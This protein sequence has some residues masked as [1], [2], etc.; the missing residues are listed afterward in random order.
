MRKI[1]ISKEFI[2]SYDAAKIEK[3]QSNM[4]K[5][6]KLDLLNVKSLI[7]CDK[8]TGNIIFE[9]TA[10]YPQ[11]FFPLSI[12][13]YANAIKEMVKKDKEIL[14]I[15]SLS[16]KDYPYCDFNC[17]DCLADQT[18]NWA[19]REFH[20]NVLDIEKYKKILKQISVFSRNLGVESVRYEI[21]GEG[22]PDLYKN[23]NEIIKYAKEEC[24]MGIVYIST[25]SKIDFELK[26]SLVKYASYIRISLPGISDESYEFYSGQTRN[27]QFKYSDAIKL[28]EEL[29]VL[30]KDYHRE[31]DL[32][33]GVRTCMRKLNNGHYLNLAKKL[34]SIDVDSFQVV[35]V[36]TDNEYIIEKNSLDDDTRKEILFLKENYKEIGLKHLQIPNILDKLYI[37]RT[38][39]EMKKP[40]KCYSSMVSPILYGNNLIV[41][42]HWDK[43]KD[44]NNFHYGCMSGND[45]EINKLMYSFDG[46]K[47]RSK[48]P[49]S[50]DNCCALNDNLLLEAIRSQLALYNDLENIEFLLTYEEE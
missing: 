16:C 48:I 28:L 34:G 33:I 45:D 37:D 29:T 39:H 14:P 22:N 4:T 1:A 46:E 20:D 21:C 6:S 36:L 43:I 24:N 42:V 11:H 17:R 50:C 49:A 38:L 23:R 12:L 30:R 18:R 27:N 47:V 44:I 13:D 31:N 32:M 35:K 40:S 10:V 2:Y 8:S 26:K 9:T 3:A 7:M 19:I 15:L 25:G 5:F 41:C